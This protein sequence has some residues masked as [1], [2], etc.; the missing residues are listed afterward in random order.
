MT[1]VP[2]QA[3]IN[4]LVA[5]DHELS[6]PLE[7]DVL[8][9]RARSTG[10]LEDVRLGFALDAY[11]VTAEKKRAEIA[12]LLEQLKFVNAEIAAAQKD[13]VQAENV[14]VRKAKKEL[15]AQ[16]DAFK[17]E[18]AKIKQQT[19]AEVEKALKEDKKAKKVFES[20]LNAL[21]EEVY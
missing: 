13:V 12:E 9:V 8:T 20:K 18:A 17:D 14:Q 6:K 16:L 21:Y 15:D 4:A 11:E 7:D 1:G 5:A 19:E 10:K 2:T 3:E